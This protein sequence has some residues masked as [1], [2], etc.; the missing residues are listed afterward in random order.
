M[1]IHDTPVHRTCVECGGGIPIQSPATRMYCTTRCSRLAQRVRAGNLRPVQDRLCEYCKR[2]FRTTLSRQRF[3]ATNCQRAA[4]ENVPLVHPSQIE[5]GVQI[6]T[7]TAGAA[8]ELRAA[9]DL[10][11]RG[12]HV[13]R[14]MSPS[15][16]CDLVVWRPSGPVIRVEVKTARVNSVTGVISFQKALRNIFDAIC[17]VTPDEVIYEPPISEW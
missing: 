8:S 2:Q 15:C 1:Q 5:A 9:A 13:F 16:P 12:F 14:A 7:S 3:C 17:H 6:P 4:T 11:L 10:M